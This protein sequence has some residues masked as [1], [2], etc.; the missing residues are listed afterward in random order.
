M[1]LG[2]AAQGTPVKIVPV[3]LT[4]FHA[5]R[6]RSIAVTQFGQPFKCP[7]HL[8]EKYNTGDT[9]GAC[10]ELL[11]IIT[12]SLKK[13]TVNTPDYASNKQLQTVRRLFQPDNVRNLT[14]RQYMAYNRKFIAGFEEIQDKPQ[15]IE[16]L[17]TVDEY[18]TEI[19]AAN[20]LDKEVR[21]QWTYS[22]SEASR[23]NG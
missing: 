18:M 10:G 15:T 6:F 4:Y 5:H 12:D 9:R 20:W 21:E 14:G 11:E 3:G 7:P 1:A 17:K 2:A 13:V 8:V 23:G 22:A 16:L 19:A